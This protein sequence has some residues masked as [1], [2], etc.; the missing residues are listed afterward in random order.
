MDGAYTDGDVVKVLTHQGKFIGNGYINGHSKITI[1]L[2]SFHDEGINRDFFYRRIEDA[3]KYRLSLGYNINDS[4]RVVF[5]EGDL[6]PGLIVDK[7]ADMLSLQILTLG[8]ERWKK[9][10]VE[11]L[12]GL[13]NPETII[14]RSDVEVRRKEGLEPVKGIIWGK[15]K[16]ITIVNMDGLKFEIDL[17]EGH[18]T[19]FYLDQQENRRAIEPYVKGR[20]V[21]D[22]FSYTGSFALYAVK[23]GAREVLAL[24][25]SGKVM[26]M[27]K[28][29]IQLNGFEDMIKA[30]KG[31]AFQWLRDK[32]KTG[33]KFDCI[34]LDPP[35]FVKDKGARGGAAR[36]Y[37]DINL[38]ALKLL[39]NGGFLITSSC[40][41]NVSPDHFLDIIHDAAVDAGC[42]L[43]L[44]EN[45]SQSKD[46]PILLSMPQTHYLKFVVV[47]KIEK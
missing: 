38:T 17:M 36:G 47:R 24:E 3:L 25:D 9:E 19:G 6:L 13:F 11:I 4:F 1:R 5:S 37:K 15:E 10:I 12:A 40:S 32:Y 20:R 27:L 21:L 33:E 28:R 23:Y 34:M 41:Q 30:E 31:D 39:N 8:M 29:N 14:E 7:Y 42:L 22:C 16:N 43:H 26:D 35:S 46:H 18:K 44:M 45:R 2:L